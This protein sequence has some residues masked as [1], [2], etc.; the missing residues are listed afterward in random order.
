MRRTSMTVWLLLLI[1]LPA[2]ALPL[3]GYGLTMGTTFTSNLFQDSLALGDKFTGFTLDLDESLTRNLLLYYTGRGELYSEYSDLSS[4]R[5]TGGV[6]VGE[7]VGRS[8]EIWGVL[9]G[10]QFTYGEYYSR[11]NRNSGR[12]RTGWGWVMSP[13]I[14]LR[15]DLTAGAT[16]YPNA[17]TSDVDVNDY[18]ATLGLNLSLRVPLALDIELGGSSR[19]YVELPSGTSAEAFWVTV[20][21]SKPLAPSTGL[22]L[23]MTVR[24]QLDVGSDGLS[25]L[26]ESGIDPGDLLWDGWR[27]GVDLNHRRGAW[28]GSVSL[29]RG[30]ETYVETQA[31]TGRGRREDST[32]RFVVAARRS[33]PLTRGIESSTAAIGAAWLWVDTESTD[34]FYTWNGSSF[35]LT[36]ML[37]SP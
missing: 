36:L 1:A 19:Q 32:T 17:D 27:A 26:Y 22:A 29:Y 23:S 12:A 16:R 11:Y 10:E 28:S 13:A 34:T 4:L 20:R 9:E 14:R 5:H 6:E 8:G 37:I 21:A 31:L 35:M 18:A 7:Y 24:E 15:G 25:A 33:F 2:R 3:P 30:R